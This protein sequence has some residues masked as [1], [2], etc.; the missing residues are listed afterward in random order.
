MELIL[1]LSVVCWI[2][3]AMIR[4]QLISFKGIVFITLVVIGFYYAYEHSQYRYLIEEAQNTFN[5]FVT[6]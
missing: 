1:L 5:T 3:A 2:S 6:I 4:F